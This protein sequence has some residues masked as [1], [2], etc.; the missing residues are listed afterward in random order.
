VQLDEHRAR[1]TAAESRG[2]DAATRLART[3][4]DQRAENAALREELTRAESLA[5]RFSL[6][7]DAV[8]LRAAELEAAIIQ[9]QQRMMLLERRLAS[10]EEGLL[11]RDDAIASLNAELDARVAAEQDQPDVRLVVPALDPAL[12]REVLA[13]AERAEAELAAHVT[14]LANVSEAHATDTDAL[15]AQLQERAR[16]VADL[17]Q[18]V[19]RRDGLV[20]ELVTQL[21][22]LRDGLAPALPPAMPSG[23]V[24]EIA[25]LRRKA[26]ELALEVARRES[27]LVAEG[28]RAQEIEAQL[29]SLPAVLVEAPPIT[30]P[31]APPP[32]AA[33]PAHASANVRDDEALRLRDE[34]GA[35][36]QAL[37]QEHAARVAAESGEALERARA[38][39]A[40]QAVLLEQVRTAGV[41]GRD[42]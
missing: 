31:S 7:R 34:I 23:D 33:T 15:E 6:A 25:R 39:L 42:A 22:D 3:L 28:W 11:E 10:A 2:G 20:R 13:R 40:R 17:E 21:Q 8:G 9:T 12:V 37:T 27:E 19:A 41:H 5:A 30:K 16:V 36:R 38:E 26:D 1:L 35:L 4:D 32:L 18:E 14:D 24:E 29:R